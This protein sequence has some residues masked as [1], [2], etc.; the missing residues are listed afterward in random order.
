[1]A[2]DGQIWFDFSAP[3]VWVFYQWV[4]AL[5]STGTDVAIDWLPLP[6]G[7]ERAAM[8]TLLSIEQPEDR[9]R[10]L[11]AMLGLVHIEGM[12]ATDLKTI[13][14]ALQAADL[15]SVIVKDAHPLLEELRSRATELGVDAV[16][17]LFRRG[18]VMSIQFNPAILD[19]DPRATAETI[20][21]VLG[22]D[23][24]WEL[25]KP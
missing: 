2:F 20:N 10:Y 19:E 25:R 17:T 16:P 3:S 1:M 8:A 11:H 13:A 6:K 14:A 18:P 4:R 23:G 24:M 21:R 22:C 9:G 5:A 7:T 15:D 12:A